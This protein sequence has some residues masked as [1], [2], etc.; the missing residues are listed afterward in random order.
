MIPIVII[1]IVLTLI[2]LLWIKLKN[3]R[4]VI[5]VIIGVVAGVLSF[6]TYIL[7]A[8][9]FSAQ[10]SILFSLILAFY[11]SLIAF[12]ILWNLF[13]TKKVYLILAVPLICVLTVTGIIWHTVYVLEL[14]TVSEEDYEYRYRPFA[15]TSQAAKLYKETNLRFTLYDNLP[16]LDGATALYPVY[17]S[18]AQ[19]VYPK[20]D[21]SEIGRLVLCS[22]TPR[23]YEN[24]LKGEADLI[25]CAAPSD[26]QMEQF[27]HKGLNL[28]LVPIGRE[29]FVFFVNKKNIVDNITI[30]SIQGIYSGRIKNW[31]DL[32]GANQKIRAF[33]RPKDSGS[34]TALEKIM[35]NIPIMEPRR[36]DVSEGMGGIIN[37]VAIYKNF[38][39]AIGY[40]FLFY[41]TE[42]VKNDQIKLLS[43]EGIYPSRETIQ[44]GT[45]PFSHSFYAIYIDDENKNENIELFI[46]WILSE[47]GQ[48]LVE[49]TGYTPIQVAGIR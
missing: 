1:A 14:P 17:A 30:G 40:S 46:E 27:N 28:R 8:L 33:Q 31:K 15:E 9:F 3:K 13:K 34:Q 37:R 26:A 6:F 38:P 39:N 21:N 11:I 45:Y 22:R 5:A 4:V 16:V 25:F 20:K 42:M 12:L 19:A 44:N 48:E 23:A 41:S 35:G 2:L 7:L 10:S 18:F 49:K 32:N 29:A 43:V 24:L 36:E 47:Q